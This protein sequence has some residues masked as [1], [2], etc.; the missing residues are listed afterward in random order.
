VY[1]DDD[2]IDACDGCLRRTDLLAAVAGR[3]DIEWR[4][5]TGRSR[6]LALP[7]EALLELDPTRGM[8]RRY[9]AFDAG[10][11]RRRLTAS[12]LS[13]LCRCGT[14]YPARLRELDDPPAVIHVAGRVSALYEPDSVG[15]VGA[16]RA[17][18]YGLEVA[19][20]L[21][22]SLS[23]AGVPVVSGLALG[24][25]SAAHA[26]AVTAAAPP[27]AV[28]AGGADLAYPAR[29][30]AL[31]GR[32]VERGCVI[33]ELPPGFGAHRWCFVARN[34][35]IAALSAVTVLVEAAER[36]G[37]L[38]TADFAA[39]MGRTVAAVPGPVT[40]PLS[41]GTNALLQSGAVLVHDANDIVEH[42]ARGPVLDRAPSEACAMAALDALQRRVLAGVEA[43]D[44][45]PARLAS[46]SDE[47]QAVL[48]ALTALEL[49]GLVRRRFGGR[50]VRVAS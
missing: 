41:A 11:A 44:D 25:D 31:Y 8:R 21:G 45:T 14:R 10:L 1:V 47:P 26:G 40:S 36:S 29:T 43:G 4:R 38:T 42:L 5:R 24:V 34:R 12:R 50:Y 32:V 18:S 3:I 17:T 33:S 37:S 46:P 6:V 49:A 7:D 9:D 27:V 16:R 23:A 19:R 2:V 30:R 13:A 35:I 48:A 15:V 28:L 20:Q 22:R 39:Q